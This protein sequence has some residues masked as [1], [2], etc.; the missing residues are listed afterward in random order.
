MAGCEIGGGVV[1]RPSSGVFS[2]SFFFSFFFFLSFLSVDVDSLAFRLLLGATIETIVNVRCHTVE[3]IL[4]YSHAIAL[5]K[6]PNTN[7][8]FAAKP[9]GVYLILDAANLQS[10]PCVSPKIGSNRP[11]FGFW[12]AY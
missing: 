9:L 3:V 1:E 8:L 11:S 5:R 12:I 7:L 10:Y 6:K 4:N 2:F